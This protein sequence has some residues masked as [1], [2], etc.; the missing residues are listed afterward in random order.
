M[1]KINL[2]IFASGEGTNF[3]AIHE[4]SKNKKFPGKI[5]LVICDKDCPAFYL[6]KALEYETII[7]NRKNFEFE[8]KVQSHLQKNRV[9]LVCLSGFMTILSP[10][11]INKWKNKILNIHPSILP[12]YPGLNTHQKVLRSGMR[13][14]G[15]TVHLVNKKIDNGKILGQFIFPIDQDI[16]IKDLI[17]KIKINENFFYPKVIEKYIWTYFKKKDKFKPITKYYKNVTFSY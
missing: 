10:Y 11:I 14:H 16:K 15:S 8:K 2:S 9:D 17:D 13:F 7:I 4:A 12:L 5:Q 3:K 6:S 1:N